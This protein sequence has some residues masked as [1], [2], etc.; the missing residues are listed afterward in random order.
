MT[1]MLQ[2]IA[3][4]FREEELDGAS[5]DIRVVIRCP[6]AP[7][8]AAADADPAANVVNVGGSLGAAAAPATA[9]AV[10]ANAA[11]FT[12]LDSFPGLRMITN[13]SE[14]FRAQLVSLPELL[15]EHSVAADRTSGTRC[16]QEQVL[17]HILCCTIGTGDA[18]A[19]SNGS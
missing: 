7:S 11:A 13:Y 5:A 15:V 16:Y 2:H 17:L 1:T 8:V 19:H 18:A 14:Y 3:R 10:D 9:G 6:K 12:E 4:H